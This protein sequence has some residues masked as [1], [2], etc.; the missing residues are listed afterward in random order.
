[1]KLKYWPWYVVGLFIIFYSNKSNA[2]ASYQGTIRSITVGEVLKQR[3]DSEQYTGAVGGGAIGY[4]L[5]RVFSQT[6]GVIGLG[7][8]VLI[9]STSTNKESMYTFV[10]EDNYKQF[11][12]IHQ[13]KSKYQINYQ[14]GDKV[15]VSYHNGEWGVVK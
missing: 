5:G 12:T 4:G 10:I 7:I 6:T 15:F 11:Q 1:M 8:G 13:L 3:P 9:G 14:V 2:D